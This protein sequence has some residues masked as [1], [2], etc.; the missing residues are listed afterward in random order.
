MVFLLVARPAGGGQCGSS[1]VIARLCH[2]GRACGWRHPLDR[3]PVLA[4]NPV[5]LPGG[6][7]GWFPLEALG[8]GGPPLSAGPPWVVPPGR[9]WGRGPRRSP[10][11]AT[12]IVI[13]LRSPAQRREVE[14]W[15][16]S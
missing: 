2:I 6:D 13:G 4:E 16:A 1:S 15:L 8:T 5:T 3:R 14:G 12:R 11:D 9:P 10:R 7:H